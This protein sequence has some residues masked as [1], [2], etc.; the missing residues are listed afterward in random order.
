MTSATIG[1]YLHLPFCTAK[2]GYCDFNSY[3]GHEHMIPSYAGT[4]VKDASLWR[5]AVG[6]RRVETVFFGGGTPSLNPVDEM[7]KILDGM[8]ATFHIDPNAEVALEANP[9]SITT[10]YLRGLHAIGFNRLSIGVQSF[11]DEELV[12][13]DRVHTGQQARQAYAS[14][15]EAGGLDGI[16][17]R[18]ASTTLAVPFESG[19]VL[20]RIETEGEYEDARTSAG[21]D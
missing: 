11:D 12:I 16:L 3:A 5:E 6:G 14:A 20:M 9:G 2:C 4:L 13:L 7:T 19:I 10:E 17:A 18:H 8:R 15:R 21:F 1:L